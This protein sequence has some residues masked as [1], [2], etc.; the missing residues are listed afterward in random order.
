MDDVIRGLQAE[1]AAMQMKM[2]M[3]RD[4]FALAYVHLY[5]FKIQK[6]NFYIILISILIITKQF[7]PKEVLYLF[8]L[9]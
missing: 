6:D 9:A 7:G 5:R 4:E 8:G 3:E 1:E 2:G